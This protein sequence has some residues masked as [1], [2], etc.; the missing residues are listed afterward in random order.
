MTAFLPTGVTCFRRLPTGPGTHD[1]LA[2]V[3]VPAAAKESAHYGEFLRMSRAQPE[4][5]QGKDL[6]AVR[7]V[8]RGPATDP[9]PSGGRFSR[10]ERPLR[11]FPHC[12][13]SRPPEDAPSS[14]RPTARPGA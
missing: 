2:P 3:L 10:P 6:I 12:P 9:A 11:Q 8:Q 14:G 1:A 4:P 7:G 13:A 5:V